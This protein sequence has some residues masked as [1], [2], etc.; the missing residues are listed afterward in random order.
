MTWDKSAIKNWLL[1]VAESDG[2][3]PKH[4]QAITRAL[5]FMYAR[6]TASEQESKMTS[7][8]NGV[9]FNGRDAE[10]MSSVAERVKQYGRIT[11]RQT[12]AIAKGLA[13]YSGQLVE[14]AVNGQETQAKPM[15]QTI[16]MEFGQHMSVEPYLAG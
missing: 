15:P 10:F 2:T 16:D 9:G 11:P 8:N 7:N 4:Q 6:Q 13:K 1:S 12:T 14:M 5:L 3:N